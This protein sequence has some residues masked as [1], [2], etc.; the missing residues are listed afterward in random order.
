[1]KNR[2]IIVQ[3]VG[4]KQTLQ[5]NGQVCER[6]MRE[7]L[8]IAYYYP[9]LGGVGAVRPLQFSKYLPENGWRASILSVKNDSQYPKDMSLFSSVPRKQKISRGY[10]L[11]IFRTIRKLARGPLKSQPLLY[12][13]LDAHYDWVPGAVQTGK[14]MIERGNY[15]A[16]MATAPPYSSLRVARI[17]N[18]EYKI[19][20]IA[21][22]RDPFT[23]NEL[24]KWPT[25]WHKKFYSLYERKLLSDFDHVITTNESHTKDLS[26]I[27]GLPR[28]NISMITN[29]YDPESFQNISDVPPRDKFVIGYI[30]SLYGKMSPKPFFKSLQIA[31]SERPAMRQ[32]LQVIFVG[33][34]QRELIES[35][36]KKASIDDVLSI[37][38]YLP[39]RKAISFMHKCHLLLLLSGMVTRSYTAK[40]FE[41]ASAGKSILSFDNAEIFGDFMTRK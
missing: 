18:K 16:I 36:A 13:F 5:L 9:P 29:G 7:V 6:K 33:H 23:T 11:P 10:R 17:L 40:M 32:H 12:S 41:Y 30:G 38:G 25:R 8:F 19:P 28:K 3:S 37:H 20:I 4:K 14:K 15:E 27:I 39:H 35:E 34:M 1:M 22:M 26:R 24:M 31:L 2:K 21:D